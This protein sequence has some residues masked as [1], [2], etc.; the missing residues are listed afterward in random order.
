MLLFLNIS[1]LFIISI[2]KTLKHIF[3]KGLYTNV[4]NNFAQKASTWKQ[5][6]YQINHTK[7]P[8]K[9]E[10]KNQII[11]QIQ[12]KCFR[13]LRW[14]P[15]QIQSIRPGLSWFQTLNNDIETKITYSTNNIYEHVCKILKKLL[16]NQTPKELHCDQVWF[17]YRRVTKMDW[18][19][20]L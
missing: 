7:S 6:K 14:N 5:V 8:K 10:Q 11:C 2:K 15:S 4:R 1:L 12:P 13:K 16:A 19:T 17:I 9:G 3:I 18:N 20:N